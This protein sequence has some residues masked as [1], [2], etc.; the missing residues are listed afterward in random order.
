MMEA[1]SELKGLA[2]LSDSFINK[3]KSHNRRLKEWFNLFKQEVEDI[4]TNQNISI[5]KS[6]DTLASEK[7]LPD[8]LGFVCETGKVANSNLRVSS[9]LACLKKD[10][11]LHTKRTTPAKNSPRKTR[12]KSSQQDRPTG[13]DTFV[14]FT[15]PEN[16]TEKPVNNFT[17]ETSINS[18]NGE[19]KQEFYTPVGQNPELSELQTTNAGRTSRKRKSSSPL[20]SASNV[21]KVKAL[22]NETVKKSIIRKSLRGQ[23]GKLSESKFFKY[24]N[25]LPS[26]KISGSGFNSVLKEN[27]TSRMKPEPED[28]QPMKKVL[29]ARQLKAQEAKRK[30]EEKALKISQQRMKLEKEK[31]EKRSRRA[32]EVE[33]PLLKTVL[34]TK[35][36]RTREVEKNHSEGPN[37]SHST[38]KVR[39]TETG[40]PVKTPRKNAT[41]KL[42]EKENKREKTQLVEKNYNSQM[43]SNPRSTQEINQTG[44]PTKTPRKVAGATHKEG[45]NKNAEVDM[46]KTYNTNSSNT[47][48]ISV[49]GTKVVSPVKE[50]FKTPVPPQRTVPTVKDSTAVNKQQTS[51]LASK[52]KSSHHVTGNSQSYEMTPA[53]ESFVNYDISEIKSDDSDDDE[54]C[55]RN[56]KPVPGWASGVRLK[57]ALVQQ[58][59]RPI[60]T[61]LIFGNVFTTPN[62]EEIMGVKSKRYFKRTSSAVWNSPSAFM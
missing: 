37:D 25:R 20:V 49:A 38:K 52:Q 50:V 54:D 55:K 16:N 1:F 40:T 36:K 27:R 58:Q 3:T 9:A 34:D 21:K 45:G 7:K 48:E 28:N 57:N 31:D 43:K 47:K 10:H 14:K 60:D 62:L 17:N 23:H 11:I 44:T 53:R 4:V 6:N 41:E 42:V 5:S 56:P 19:D 2:D 12:G 29:A 46:N 32:K 35:K 39:G 8:I 24:H 30:R 22:N 51:P 61:D 15:T 13:N 18:L 59:Y 26:A 33:K